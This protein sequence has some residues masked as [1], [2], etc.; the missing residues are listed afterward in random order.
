MFQSIEI[1]TA[2]MKITPRIEYAGG[3]RGWVGDSPRIDLD[4]TRIR[5]LGWA[6]S[7]TIPQCIVETL[8]F[9]QDNPYVEHRG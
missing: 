6:P 5:G 7:K 3:E 4:T 9:L 2:E 1:I 8:R